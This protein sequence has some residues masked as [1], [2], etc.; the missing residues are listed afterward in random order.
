MGYFGF[1][2]TFLCLV[3]FLHQVSSFFFAYLS[4]FARKMSHI[5]LSQPRPRIWI[6]L[7]TRANL[8]LFSLLVCEG[9]CLIASGKLLFSVSVKGVLAFHCWVILNTTKPVLVRSWDCR[10]CKVNSNPPIFAFFTRERE[11][12]RECLEGERER[13]WKVCPEYMLEGYSPKC[14]LNH[15]R[16]FLSSFSVISWLFVAA[17]CLLSALWQAFRWPWNNCSSCCRTHT[18]A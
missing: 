11:R 16:C 8:H 15:G 13:A 4:L 12:E 7:V 10:G 18:R 9:F 14:F 6:K 1:K 3:D 2:K 17:S 5:S